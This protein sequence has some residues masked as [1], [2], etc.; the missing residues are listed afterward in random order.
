MCDR[1]P[2]QRLLDMRSST[3][4]ASLP[5][6]QCFTGRRA[7]SRPAGKGSW[8]PVR[9]PQEEVQTQAAMLL[10]FMQGESLLVYISPGLQLFLYTVQV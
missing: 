9:Q 2:Y 6:V 10:A 7:H 4:A 1:N 8:A 5:G 3:I